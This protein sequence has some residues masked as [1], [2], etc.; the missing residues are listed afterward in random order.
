MIYQQISIKKALNQ[1]YLKVSVTRQDFDRFQFQLQQLINS[2]NIQESEEFHKNLIADFLKHSFYSP[3]HFI[4]TKG[5]YDLVIH[6]G[7]DGNSKVGVIIETKSPKN[8]SEMCQLDD[9]NRKA[10]QELLLYFLQE[11]FINNNLEIKHLI[12]TNNLQ[13]FI[14]DSQVFEQ[15]FINDKALIKQFTDFNE[16][17]LTGK[18]TDYFYQEIAFPAIEKIKDNLIFTYFDLTTLTPQPPLPLGEG[19]L[20]EEEKLALEK[21][22]IPLYKIFTPEHLLKLPFVNDSNTLNKAFYTE[23]LYI[24]GL[25]EVKEGNKKLIQGK[26]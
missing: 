10:L 13:W 25:T 26:H 1:A 20:G 14:F 23:L 22:L 18:K 21:K 7:K 8:K 19:E 2:I 3:R 4:N 9:L 12:I 5:R 16:N 17:R 15:C 24:M 11:R 6:T